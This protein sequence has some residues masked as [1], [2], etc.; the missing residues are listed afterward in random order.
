MN[1]SSN[2]TQEQK[3]AA[4]ST[5]GVIGR[6]IEKLDA[7]LKRKAGEKPGDGGCCGGGK[8]GGKCC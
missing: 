6:L 7:F 1:S 4:K 3:A 5:Q 8:G 2:Q